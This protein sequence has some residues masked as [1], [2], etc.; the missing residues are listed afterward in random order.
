MFIFS[1][2]LFCISA[3]FSA[4]YV[5]RQNQEKDKAHCAALIVFCPASCSH[6]ILFQ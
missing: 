5:E 3:C 1:L 2:T 4:A 6:A